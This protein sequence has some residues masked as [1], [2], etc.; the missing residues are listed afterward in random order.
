MKLCPIYYDD[1]SHLARNCPFCAALIREVEVQI[2][3]HE[4]MVIKLQ[5]RLSQ[6]FVRPEVKR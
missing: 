6:A 5:N 4:A 1:P 2:E 3:G